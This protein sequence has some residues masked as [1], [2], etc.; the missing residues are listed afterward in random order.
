MASIRE[1]DSPLTPGPYLMNAG[2]LWQVRRTYDDKNDTLFTSILPDAE[3]F[4]ALRLL[5][6]VY[7]TLSVA[8]PSRICQERSC[9]LPSAGTRIVV[10]HMFNIRGLRTSVGNRDFIN[11][12][13]PCRDTASAIQHLI[14]AGGEIL[15]KSKISSFAAREEPTESVD[16]QAP[17]NPRGDGYQSPAGSSSGSAAAVSSYNWLDF[18]I[19]SENSDVFGDWKWAQA[20]SLEWVGAFLASHQDSAQIE[21]L[22]QD[23]R[24]CWIYLTRSFVR[25]TVERMFDVPCFFARDI[26]KFKEF[27]CAWYGTDLQPDRVTQVV[28]SSFAK[29]HTHI[30][31]KP[32]KILY[33]L[34]YTEKFG[35]EQ[36]RLIDGFVR[37][38]ESALG[39][40][41]TLLSLATEWEM[42]APAPTQAFFYD[43]YHGFDKFREDFD[44]EYNKAPYVSPMLRWRWE[45][46]QALTRDQREDA[47][48]RLKIFRGWFLDKV[49]RV[50]HYTS[51]MVFPIEEMAPRYRDEPP[52]PP[53]MPKGIG[54][55]DIAPTLGAPELVI[56]KI[57][58]ES[59]VSKG[60][61]FLP[62]AV[63][64][65]GPP[66]S[67]VGLIDVAH[68]KTDQGQEVTVESFIANDKNKLDFSRTAEDRQERAKGGKANDNVS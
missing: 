18:A 67:D 27:A 49:M 23:F 5:R 9:K 14:D 43:L 35:G 21:R 36:K 29:P 28:F 59:R 53:T 37:D 52:P 12:Y 51:F 64:L 2:F 11:L 56:P 61:E 1:F 19:G 30:H 54:M 7:R 33:P 22:C 17:F 45:V 31:G 60:T 63:S 38:L 66:G 13:P 25:L 24:V 39:V 65:M 58:Y 15:G 47:I 6:H 3:R 44:A 41:R 4:W 8:V 16:Y 57:S 32:P 20:G 34:D 55:L 68:V 46:A 10:K 62:V 50:E 42:S 48:E 26:S 40:K